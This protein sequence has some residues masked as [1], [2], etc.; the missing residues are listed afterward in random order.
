[1]SHFF[2]PGSGGSGGSVTIETITAALIDELGLVEGDGIRVAAGGLVFEPI[3][4][5]T[6]AEADVAPT[7][8]GTASSTAGAITLNFT[9]LTEIMTT[10]TENITGITLSGLVDYQTVFWTVDQTTARNITWPAATKMAGN[11]GL[12]LYTGTANSRV[13]FSIRKESSVVYVGVSDEA[14][15]GA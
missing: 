1:M 8:P 10:T 11:G 12:L 2:G 14:V 7:T 13:T 15:T 5:G 4:F 3:P 6:G 9:G